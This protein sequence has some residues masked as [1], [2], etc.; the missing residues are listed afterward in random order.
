MGVGVGTG[1]I[2][3]GN[4]IYSSVFWIGCLDLDL[5]SEGLET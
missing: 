2:Q 4:G 1:V 3:Q 5:C